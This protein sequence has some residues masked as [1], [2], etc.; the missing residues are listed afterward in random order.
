MNKLSTCP[1]CG[2]LCTDCERRRDDR[3]NTLRTQMAAWRISNGLTMQQA[4][5]LT[6]CTDPAW[7]EWERGAPLSDVWEA[8]VRQVLL[9]NGGHAVPPEPEDDVP[10]GPDGR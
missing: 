7:F 9:A 6:G 4:A 1:A 5:I 10:P 3:Q 8:R 2:A